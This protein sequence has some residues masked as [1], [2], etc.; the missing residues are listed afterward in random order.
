M[1]LLFTMFVAFD[2]GLRSVLGNGAGAAFNP[3]IAFG[4]AY[5]S[6]TLLIAGSLTTT[7]SSVTRHLSTDWVRMARVNKQM[8]AVQKAQMEA[9]RR[10][11]PAKVK[12][13]K[14]LQTKMRQDTM[15]VQTAQMK[16]V[17][18]TMVPFIVFFSWLSQFVY[19]QVVMEGHDFFAVPWARSASL[20]PIYGIFP[21][22]MLVYILFSIP[23]GQVVTRT[24][25]LLQFRKRLVRL[26]PQGVPG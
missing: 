15:G 23:I 25:K 11:N 6:V 3:T 26:G 4:G 16:P 13:L 24:L 22:W 8:R 7:I 1:I 2:P 21:A 10:G 20:L 5:P 9:L 17:L 19:V 18:F 12:K 14:E